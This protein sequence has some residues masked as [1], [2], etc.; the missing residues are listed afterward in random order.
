ML[1]EMMYDGQPLVIRR[2]FAMIIEDSVLRRLLDRAC[3]QQLCDMAGVVFRLYA[4]AID[5]KG[6]AKS[7]IEI[8]PADH[9]RL[10]T[11]VTKIFARFE[12]GE[13]WLP[14]GH[15]YGALYMQAVVP[16]LSANNSGMPSD[17]LGDFVIRAG[18]AVLRWYKAGH[19]S[20]LGHVKERLHHHYASIARDAWPNSDD[21][22][23]STFYPE[24]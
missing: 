4:I 24:A 11:A 10:E 1:L 9:K 3:T 21:P 2:G 16:W 22:V 13:S 8:A 20:E 14:N 12:Q 18:N 7:R 19:S 17:C 5:H 15:F 23:Y 6:N